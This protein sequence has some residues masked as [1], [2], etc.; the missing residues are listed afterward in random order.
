MNKFTS[1]FIAL[2]C[3]TGLF[4]QNGGGAIVEK[5]FHLF[6]FSVNPSRMEAGITLGQAGS[7]TPYAHFGAGAY[8]LYGGVY[9]DFIVAEPQHKFNG[10]LSDTD[11]NDTMAFCINA[12]YQIP[13]VSWLRIMPLLGYC[14]TNE[15]ITKG[16]SLHM[17]T[18]ENGTTWYHDYKVTPGTRIHRFNYGA[19]LSIQPCKWFSVNLVATRYAIYGGIG[20]DILT[21]AHNP[22]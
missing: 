4:A 19:G 3:S 15:G 1:L 12:G 21:L 7:F 11:W 2:I 5:E 8:F 9:A 6:D 22:F 14:Q 13:V 20:L 16:G 17:S 18:D 10:E